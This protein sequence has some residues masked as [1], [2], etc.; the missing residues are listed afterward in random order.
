MSDNRADASIIKC[1]S[2][3]ND[4]RIEKKTR[5]NLFD[6]IGITICAVIGGADSWVE[7]EE[8]GN[9]KIEWLHK[10]LKLPNGVPSHDTFGRV[11]SLIDPKEF[12]KCFHC[13]P[14]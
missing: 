4:P 13:C 3:L 14:R 10:F 9:C 12:Q 6:I 11:F 1:F 8:Y 2:K 5:H 7:I